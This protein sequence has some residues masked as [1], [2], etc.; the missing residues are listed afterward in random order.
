M[1]TRSA[2][3]APFQGSGCM[4]RKRREVGVILVYA[5]VFVAVWYRS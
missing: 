2:Y 4:A 5:I 1:E 3:L